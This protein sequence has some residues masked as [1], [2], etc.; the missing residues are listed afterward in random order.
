MSL[1]Q[2]LVHTHPHELVPCLHAPLPPLRALHHYMWV[3]LEEG[4]PTGSRASLLS[5]HAAVRPLSPQVGEVGVVELAD[6]TDTP[7]DLAGH[8]QYSGDLLHRTDCCV[9]VHQRHPPLTPHSTH[10][11][12]LSLLPRQLLPH[13]LPWSAGY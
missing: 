4:A 6:H 5:Q 7:V 12:V 9:T 10:C 8:L 3:G 1:L 11:C 13:P 2:A